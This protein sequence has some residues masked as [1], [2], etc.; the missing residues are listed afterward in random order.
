MKIKVLLVFCLISLLKAQEGSNNAHDTLNYNAQDGSAN[1]ID[2]LQNKFAL[3]QADHEVIEAD[4]L[5]DQQDSLSLEKAGPAF[6][7][8]DK[9]SK[10]DEPHYDKLDA[11]DALNDMKDEP[12]Y[13]EFEEEDMAN[14]ELDEPHFDE[15]M[16]DNENKF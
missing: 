6:D 2:T 12:H 15:M 1:A 4:K 8:M 16:E 9:V 3:S 10:N 5:A 7:L 13:D 11:I 14:G